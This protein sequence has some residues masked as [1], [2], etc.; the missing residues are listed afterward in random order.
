VRQ[1]YEMEDFKDIAA[2]SLSLPG[3]KR[4]ASLSGVALTIIMNF[5][6]CSCC[7]DKRSAGKSAPLVTRRSGPD[8][9]DRRGYVRSYV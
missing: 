9:I 6:E 4:P 8:G 2:N 1:L 3:G 5:M 7:W